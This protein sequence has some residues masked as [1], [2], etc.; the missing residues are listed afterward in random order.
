MDQ[1]YGLS[2]IADYPAIFY[3]T[4]VSSPQPVP[5]PQSSH[6]RRLRLVDMILA[7]WLL[8]L[9]LPVMVLIAVAIKCTS[10]GPVIFAH[11][12]LG[13]GGRRF[14]CL[15]FRSMTLDADERLARLLAI[16]PACRAEWAT[17]QKLRKDPRVTRLGGFLRKTSL[18]E[19]PQLL[20]VLRG[21]MSLVGPR[22]IVSAEIRRYG[23]YIGH[24]YAVRPGIT[25]LWQVNGRNNV[26]YARRVALDVLYV[27]SR[28]LP[29]YLSILGLTLPR[30]IL[31]DGTF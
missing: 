18:D 31:A 7:L 25:G 6:D 22:P 28:S 15:K 10:P 24:Y 5:L 17:A 27:R 12:R 19:L 30:V 14:A 16:D 11:G 4:G 21:D 20:N 9:I 29:L 13:Q 23:R 3:L 2:A 26:S 1:E 8:L